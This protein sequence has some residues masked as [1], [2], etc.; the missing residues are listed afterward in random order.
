MKIDIG[1][2]YNFTTM[3]NMKALQIVL[4]QKVIHNG[5]LNLVA[6]D[7]PQPKRLIN[8]SYKIPP[9]TLTHYS[10]TSH[11]QHFSHKRSL[12]RLS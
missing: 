8:K 11:S 5:C 3:R 4:S 12:A 10:H 1:A 2:G 6:C 9:K 7:H